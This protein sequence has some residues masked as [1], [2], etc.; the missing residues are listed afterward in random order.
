M[1]ETSAR[2]LEAASGIA[3]ARALGALAA[4][5]RIRAAAALRQPRRLAEGECQLEVVLGVVV[6]RVERDRLAEPLARAHDE[7]RAVREVAEGV[8]VGDRAEQIGRLG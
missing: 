7:L 5:S 3:R 2:S 4:R 6:G 1:H 8:G